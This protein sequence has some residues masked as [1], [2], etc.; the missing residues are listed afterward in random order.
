MRL[1]RVNNRLPQSGG[2]FNHLMSNELLKGFNAYNERALLETPKVNIKET[3]KDFSISV[4][5]PGYEKRDFNVSLENG[6]L[7]IEAEKELNSEE[8][9]THYEYNFGSFKRSFNLP[10][11]KVKESK[12]E[13]NYKDGIL[14]ILLPKKEE[15]MAKPKRLIDIF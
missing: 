6:V 11:D 8:K 7:T 3:D 15:A 10:E 2:L 13:A 12:I 9:Y 1:V 14:S 4:A 5:A